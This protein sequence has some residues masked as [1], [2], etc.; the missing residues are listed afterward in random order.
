M[1]DMNDKEFIMKWVNE[2]K[3]GAYVSPLYV[4]NYNDRYTLL[5]MGEI[6][7]FNPSG[8]RVGFGIHISVLDRFSFPNALMSNFE[9][10]TA[11]SHFNEEYNSNERY[12]VLEIGNEVDDV[13]NDGINHNIETMAYDPD[14]KDKPMKEKLK[15][16]AIHTLEQIQYYQNMLFEHLSKQQEEIRKRR[17]QEALSE[18]S[19]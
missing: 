7:N 19:Q 5:E 17:I 2:R 18:Y 14:A 15:P 16:D 11:F 6:D 3:K 10:M 9:C 13:L 8:F 12:I 4:K 1:F